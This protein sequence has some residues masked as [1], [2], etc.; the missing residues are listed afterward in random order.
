VA[1]TKAELSYYNSYKKNPSDFN[2][3]RYEGQI[4]ELYCYNQ[5]LVNPEYSKINLCK[6]KAVTKK[7]FG[8]FAYSKDGKI[9]YSSDKIHLA[10][11]D[12]LGMDD[13]NIY[14]F[15]VT[16]TTS[17]PNIKEEN[18]KIKRKHGLLKLLFPNKKIEFSI[19][20]PR[21]CDAYHYKQIIIVEPEYADYHKQYFDLTEK[22]NTLPSIQILQDC[23]VEFHFIDELYKYSDTLFN[24]KY[25]DSE[26]LQEIAIFEFLYDI[27][28]IN[29][30]IFDYYDVLEGKYGKVK[31]I[32]GNIY[33]DNK[34]SK[35]IKIKKLRQMINSEWYNKLPEQ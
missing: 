2:K 4:Y 9:N 34:K 14:W 3:S 11:F 13:E 25:I 19:I 22:V 35:G 27:N 18:H 24:K 7:N 29:E 12:I 26:Y 17:K 1:E 5:L 30:D 23:A 6:A 10:E 20:T 8:N 16:K 31:C 15:E 33:K 28:H 32:G 21:E